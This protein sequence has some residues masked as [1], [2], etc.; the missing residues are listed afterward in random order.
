MRDPEL[1]LCSRYQPGISVGSCAIYSVKY[2]GFSYSDRGQLTMNIVITTSDGTVFLWEIVPTYLFKNTYS[3][4]TAFLTEIYV[5]F[6]Y[7]Y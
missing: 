2:F 5:N 4:A 3:S 1:N 6:Q 7:E